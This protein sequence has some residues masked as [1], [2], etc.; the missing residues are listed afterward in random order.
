MTRAVPTRLRKGLT[1][2]LIGP[3]GDPTW[4][5]RVCSADFFAVHTDFFARAQD[6][7][8]VASVPDAAIVG[9]SSSGCRTLA[10]LLQRA[11]AGKVPILI[12]ERAATERLKEG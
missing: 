2:R 4:R 11:I 7:D 8:F 10:T 5:G 1:R 3:Y 12:V 9:P 6:N